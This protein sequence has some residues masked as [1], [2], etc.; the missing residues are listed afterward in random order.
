MKFVCSS[1]GKKRVA[2]KESREVGLDLAWSSGSSPNETKML[3]S[4]EK[5]I[6]YPDTSVSSIWKGGGA[7]RV[8]GLVLVEMLFAS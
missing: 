2:V 3:R 8:E 1:T 6:E 7:G 4:L 5:K